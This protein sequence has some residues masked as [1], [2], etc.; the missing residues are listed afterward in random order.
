MRRYGLLIRGKEQKPTF[1]VVRNTDTIDATGS[2]S[3]YNINLRF[4]LDSVSYNLSGTVRPGHFT[5]SGTRNGEWMSWNAEKVMCMQKKTSVPVPDT[6]NLGAIPYPFQAF[7]NY[8]Q[9]EPKSWLIT[10]TTV[11][12]NEAG[13]FLNKPMYSSATG[14]SSV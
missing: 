3:G 6:L 2:L 9:P 13:A 12:T 8:T 1:A 14:R 11:W 5:G 10:N 4:R 7:G